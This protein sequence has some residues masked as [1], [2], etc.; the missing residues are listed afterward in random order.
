MSEIKRE[1]CRLQGFRQMV[2]QGPMACLLIYDQAYDRQSRVV[3]S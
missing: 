1:D 3:Q 2:P